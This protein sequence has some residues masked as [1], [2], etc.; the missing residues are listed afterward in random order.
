MKRCPLCQHAY[1]DEIIRFCR[2]DGTLLI[3][4]SFSSDTGPTL[5]LPANKQSIA[6]STQMLPNTPSIAVLPFVHMS[7]D[8]D[9][10]YFCDGLAEELLNALTKIEDLK[11]AARTSAFSFKGKNV[12]LSEIGNALH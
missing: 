12:E 1:T 9:N 2:Q 8:S 11:V 10:E 7:A 5:I 6:P 4:D 3:S